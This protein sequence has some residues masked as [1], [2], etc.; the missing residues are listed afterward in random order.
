MG[1][2]A[3]ASSCEFNIVLLES[4]GKIFYRNGIDNYIKCATQRNSCIKI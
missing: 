2:Y 3:T 4:Y 1:R